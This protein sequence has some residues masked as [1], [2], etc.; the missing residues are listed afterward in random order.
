MFRRQA[1]EYRSVLVV[2]GLGLS[3]AC[4]IEPV[5]PAPVGGFLTSG[6]AGTSPR[7]GVTRWIRPGCQEAREHKSFGAAEKRGV[8][9]DGCSCRKVPSGGR[10]G[11]SRG[12]QPRPRALE[13]TL[14]R[15]GQRRSVL[16]LRFS[17]LLPSDLWA[18]GYTG[19]HSHC[20]FPP[21]TTAAR[22]LSLQI[23]PCK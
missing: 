21:R 5:S 9:R 6:A 19:R 14:P 22:P 15:P 8:F 20:T 11:E 12:Y 2:H 3:A 1:L 23:A 18:T 10:A 16:Q 13:M 7:P 17:G 4:G